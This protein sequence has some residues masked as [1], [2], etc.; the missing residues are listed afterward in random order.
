QAYQNAFT[1]T[2]IRKSASAFEAAAE[3]HGHGFIRVNQDGKISD[4][5]HLAG[6]LLQ[7]Y[8]DH[9]PQ[10]RKSLPKDILTWLKGGS[11]EQVVANQ[12]GP[13][14]FHRG[15]AKLVVR[16]ANEGRYRI[17]LLAE[18]P[19]P[20]KPAD[21]TPLGLRPRESEILFWMCQGKSNPEIATIL[22]VSVRTIHKHNE[23]IFRKLDVENRH[24]A[25]L[26]AAPLLRSV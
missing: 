18:Q 3:A 10:T 19:V 1:L 22:G 6:H 8:F 23:N 16:V 5:T 12:N 25:V 24:S 13:A 15:G 26:R 11:N 7:K 20:S 17:L 14:V 4:I 21:L 9:P 2:K